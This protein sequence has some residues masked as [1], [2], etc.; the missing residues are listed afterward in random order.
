MTM[1]RPA[2]IGITCD[3]IQAAHSQHPSRVGQNQTYIDAVV[4]AGAVPLLLPNVADLTRLRATYEHLDGL[5]LSGGGDI[6]PARYGEPV[7][8]KCGRIDSDRDEV[9]LALTRWATEDGKPLLAVCRGIQILNVALGGSLYQD[10]ESQVAGALGHTWYPDHPRT[11]LAHAV[12]VAPATYLAQILESSSL[13]VNSLHHQAIK[14]LAPS[15]LVAARSS[16]QIIEAVE[17]EGHPYALGVQWHPEDLA[18]SDVR[19]Q[20]LFDSLVGSCQS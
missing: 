16:D 7:H 15:L 14:D 17:I 2:I 13:A 4:R 18:P 19:Q 6:D 10:I 5:L 12:D 20:G 8:E 9:E 11:H 1:T 3:R